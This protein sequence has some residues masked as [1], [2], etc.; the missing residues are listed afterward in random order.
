MIGSSGLSVGIDLVSVSRIETLLE[1]WG[2]KF[3]RRVF[4]DSE[5]EY[6]LERFRPAQSLAARFAAKEAFFKAISKWS[7]DAIGF[8]EVEV[9]VGENGGPDLRAHGV[10]ERALGKLIVSVSLSHDQD[11]A[12]AIVVTSPEVNT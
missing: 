4:T 8:K 12:I 6:C 7:T 10:A 5:I 2:D 1:R 9:V 11:L 3:L